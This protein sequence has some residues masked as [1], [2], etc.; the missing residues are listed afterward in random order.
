[1]QPVS[2]ASSARHLLLPLLTVFAAPISTGVGRNRLPAKT[3]KFPL[4]KAV[5]KV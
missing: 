5:L 1:M 3:Y 2:C 4:G